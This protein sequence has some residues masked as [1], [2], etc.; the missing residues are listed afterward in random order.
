MFNFW[1]QYKIKLLLTGFLIAVSVQGQDNSVKKI[2]FEEKKIEG[3]IRRPQLVLIKADQRPVFS[4]MILQGLGNG[5]NI[6]Q[7]V[8]NDLITD[9]PYKGAFQFNNLEISNYQK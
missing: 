4:P 9:S 5:T 7:T 2:I 3:K 6:L 1:I 8:N